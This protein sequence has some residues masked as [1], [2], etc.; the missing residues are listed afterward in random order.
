ML[1]L[2]VT[3]ISREWLN[4]FAPD[5]QGRQVWSLNRMRFN[6]KV[7]G[8]GHQGQKRAQRCR[9]LLAAYEWYALAAIK[10]RA[11]AADG[12]IASLPGVTS[13][14]CAQCMFGKTSLALV[15]PF[16]IYSLIDSYYTLKTTLL[17]RFDQL[18]S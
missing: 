4:G 3:Q 5:S 10:Q 7:K 18:S 13:G 17:N 2:I 12:T 9:H 8:Q 6:V 14:T 16:F 15:Y 1:C 11:A